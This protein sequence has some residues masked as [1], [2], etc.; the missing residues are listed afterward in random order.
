[1]PKGAN[2]ILYGEAWFGPRELNNPTGQCA[3]YSCVEGQSVAA[4]NTHYSLTFNP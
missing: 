4:A 3:S 1:M 2:F